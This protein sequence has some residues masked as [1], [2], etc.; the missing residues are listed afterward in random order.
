MKTK[1]VVGLLSAAGIAGVCVF[2]LAPGVFRNPV[3]VGE[4]IF[5][6][7]L[8]G[9]LAVTR[10]IDWPHFEAMGI[11][12][13]KEY[14]AY[15]RAEQKQLYAQF[16]L[17]SIPVGF[18]RAQGEAKSFVNWRLYEKTAGRAVVAADDAAHGKT[19]LLTLTNDLGRWKLTAISWDHTGAPEAGH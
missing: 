8:S 6:R 11:D 10:S 15:A 1:I 7:M 12:V 14:R 19:L 4:G 18:Q 9:D 16:L 5:T 17:R 2:I 3:D 13:G